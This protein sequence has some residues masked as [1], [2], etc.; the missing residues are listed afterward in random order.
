MERVSRQQSPYRNPKLATPVPG[1]VA[2]RRSSFL[3]TPILEELVLEEFEVEIPLNLSHF[4]VSKNYCQPS[5]SAISEFRN[6]YF[7]FIQL[8]S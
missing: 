2:S 3:R 4:P 1:A 5:A 6:C 7:C 8:L